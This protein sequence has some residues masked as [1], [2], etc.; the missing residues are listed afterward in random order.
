MKTKLKKAFLPLFSVF[1]LLTSCSS[2]EDN[3]NNQSNISQSLANTQWV[4]DHYEYLSDEA[5]QEDINGGVIVAVGNEFTIQEI[6]DKNNLLWADFFVSF[7]ND[8]TGN[9]QD[10][11]TLYDD[12][13][14]SMEWSIVNDNTLRI[15]YQVQD[16]L[17]PN[18]FDTQIVNLE[19][20]TVE[21]NVFSWEAITLIRMQGT[22]IDA[23]YV[24]PNGRYFFN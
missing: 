24:K 8:G 10:F 15:V 6:E 7:N 19:N 11:S 18:T 2:D 21:N 13:I 9:T 1:I 16:D 12:E 23:L 17:D 22:G 3:S 14:R 5:T 4:F 20:V